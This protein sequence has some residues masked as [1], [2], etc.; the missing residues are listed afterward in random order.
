MFEE[1]LTDTQ[2]CSKWTL[3]QRIEIGNCEW[4]K[5][6]CLLGEKSLILSICVAKVPDG[7]IP[8]CLVI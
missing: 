1:W 2:K 5:G 8:K 3:V 6:S 7:H 4:S